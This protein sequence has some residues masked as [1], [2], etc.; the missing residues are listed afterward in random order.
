MGRP[1][2]YYRIWYHTRPKPGLNRSA[3]QAPSR[4]NRLYVELLKEN[5][6]WETPS[7]RHE[8]NHLM[9]RLIFCFFAE[10][11][12]IFPEQ[13]RFTRIID[14][15]SSPDGSNTHEV[16][17]E[18]FQAMNTPVEDRAAARLPRWVQGFP[19][20]NGGLFS[21]SSEAPRF[22]RIAR[23]YLLHIGNL[24]W[25]KI[26]PDIFGSMVQAVAVKEERGNLGMHYTSVPNIL[27]VLNPLFLDDL[28]EKLENAGDNGRQL[29][30][31]R[32]RL[33]RIRV[34]D[35]A[36]GS[37][38]F[39]V[40]AYK[41]MRAIEAEI[42]RRR[43]E[44]ERKSDIPISNFRGIEIADF[45]AEIAR[46][47]LMIA[48]YQCNVNYLG[49][50]EAVAVV[51]PLDKA[52]WITCANALRVDWGQV[53]PP[54]GTGVKLVSDDL[55][56]TPLDQPEI[57]FENQGGETYLCGNPPY[58]GSQWQTAEQKA[59]LK[60]VFEGRTTKWRSLDYVAGWF[61]K[62]AD[63]MTT[64]PAAAAF[65]A[66]NSVCQGRQVAT[67]W[68]LMLGTGHKIAFAHT[69]FKW[70]NLASHNAG[71]T[72][73]IVGVS[74]RPGPIRRLYSGGA[75]GET[76]VRETRNINPYLVSGPDVLVRPRR[77]SMA[78]LHEMNF[79][80]MPNEGGY[81]LAG[82]FRCSGC[83]SASWCGSS[84]HSVVR[85]VAGVHPRHPAT[86]H[87]GD[88]RRLSNCGG[89]RVARCAVRGRPCKAGSFRSQNHE[90]ARREA[91]SIR[92]GSPARR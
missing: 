85:G 22:S 55:F 42:N 67:L 65:V 2:A 40:I 38:N 73:A 3:A 74:N 78:D 9:A 46:L 48:E 83:D 80:N 72:V 91:T 15:M 14:Q 4:L 84:L 20:V 33:A 26:N 34:F 81:L 36:C 70:A 11:T 53:C 82:S 77:E 13:A 5:P 69:S 68:S 61:M 32:N 60:S 25:K 47:A 28:R 89:E 86:L 59:D 52:N 90:A 8:M 57:S 58:R 1:S 92:R 24:D 75:E 16:L 76:T 44:R 45:S 35:P 87:L 18:L 37:G 7:R 49:Q 27:K 12:D 31:L 66:T 79:G 71:V 41:E 29:L 51:L 19:Y 21:D 50:R 63:Y 30:N 43:E 23:S 56:H 62:A 17:D 54:T 39:L 6:E 10:D 64:T 88:R